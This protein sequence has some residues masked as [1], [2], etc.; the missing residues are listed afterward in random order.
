MVALFH[1]QPRFV[2]AIY[3]M[4]AADRDDYRREATKKQPQKLST[5]HIVLLPDAR[6]SPGARPHYRCANRASGT[7]LG[8]ANA[9]RWWRGAQ[10]RIDSMSGKYALWPTSPSKTQ[11]PK[12]EMQQT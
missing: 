9:L 2:R 1:L 11:S 7:E 4:C 12:P 5:I 6:Q 3:R 10:M 8:L